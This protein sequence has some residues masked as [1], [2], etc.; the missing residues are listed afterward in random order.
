MFS[1][2]EIAQKVEQLAVRINA[3][4]SKRPGYGTSENIGAPYI[5]V[6]DS[7]YYFLAFD[8]DVRT[9]NRKTQDVNELLYWVFAYITS[10]MSSS[11]AS[12]HR[13]LNIDY[14]KVMFDYQLE[15]LEELDPVWRERRE[16]EI[17]EILKNNPYSS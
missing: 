15:L 9:L 13:D 7:N 5:E 17:E 16:K 2:T 10:S 12:S 4:S 3:P 6:D 1:L 11:Y 14:R 8:R